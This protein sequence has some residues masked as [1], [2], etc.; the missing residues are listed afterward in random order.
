MHK[1]SESKRFSTSDIIGF[2]AIT[3]MAFAMAACQTP[4]QANTVPLGKVVAQLPPDWVDL[5][6]GDSRLSYLDAPTRLSLMAFRKEIAEDRKSQEFTFYGGFSEGTL[7]RWR[8]INE[9]CKSSYCA[10]AV[11]IGRDLTPELAGTS[12]SVNEAYMNS[13]IVGD[14]DLRQVQDDWARIW[15]MNKP[16][17]LSPYPIVNTGG[18]P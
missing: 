8:E 6:P 11:V 1:K 18:R 10:N 16:S 3:A 4:N 14:V 5:M 12:L 17:T 7:R 13:V 15:L 2:F 9:E